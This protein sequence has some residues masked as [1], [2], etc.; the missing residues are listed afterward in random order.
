MEGLSASPHQNRWYDWEKR[1]KRE[2][3]NDF[4]SIS[5]SFSSIYSF[6][7][8]CCPFSFTYKNALGAPPFLSSPFSWDRLRC[9]GSQ[10]NGKKSPHSS[11][12]PS[13]TAGRLGK[14]GFIRVSNVLRYRRRF[15]FVALKQQI[16]SLWVVWR[17]KCG[18]ARA[19][20]SGVQRT[21][22]SE[23]SNSLVYIELNKCLP[24]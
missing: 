16:R 24:E 2:R 14:L 4:L 22:A 20:P 15:Y 3:G 21:Q 9:N 13:R 12:S 11:F 23:T 5:I 1:V 7:A 19:A 18:G 17:P 10:E 8:H 6:V